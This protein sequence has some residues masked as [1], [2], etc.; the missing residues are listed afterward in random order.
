VFQILT[1]FHGNA[2]VE[3][4]FST[5]KEC[6]VENLQEDSLIAQRV[7]HDAVSAAGGITS[8][9]ITKPLILAVRNASV[10]RVEALKKKTDQDKEQKNKLKRVATE[11][12]HFEAKKTRI[13]EQAK[14]EAE[15]LNHEL[16]KL[17]GSL[18]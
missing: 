7:V 17:R 5:N 9:Q 1:L 3:K 15:A 12:K 14:E 2:A 8:I 16:Q 18:I 10:K 13:M 11:I 4:S 6:L